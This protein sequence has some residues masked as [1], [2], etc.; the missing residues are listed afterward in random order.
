MSRVAMLSFSVMIPRR[1]SAL[2]KVPLSDNEMV[3]EAEGGGAAA[4]K[5]EEHHQSNLRVVDT[6]SMSMSTFTEEEKEKERTKHLEEEDSE[7]VIESP[8]EDSPR[9]FPPME[10]S[11]CSDV[12]SLHHEDHIDLQIRILENASLSVIARKDFE[13]FPVHTLQCP[14]S[15]RRTEFVSF[16]K[17]KFAH[18]ASD[19]GFAVVRAKKIQNV[20]SYKLLS[21]RPRCNFRTRWKNAI[22]L[23][24]KQNKKDQLIEDSS[25]RTGSEEESSNNGEEEA[26]PEDQNQ[27]VNIRIR[28]LEDP[29]IQ[30]MSKEVLDRFPVQALRCPR[31]LKEEEFLSL[32]RSTFPQLAPDRPFQVLRNRPFKRL[33]RINLN[34]LTPQEICRLLQNPTFCLRLMSPLS[35]QDEEKQEDLQN[36]ELH[37]KTPPT[38]EDVVHMNV[39]LLEDLEAPQESRVIHHLDCPGDLQES[40]FLDLLRSS[41]PQ[42]RDQTVE[43]LTRTGDRLLPVKTQHQTV[44]EIR[45]NVAS[46]DD[47]VLYV[48]VQEGSGEERPAEPLLSDSP[49]ADPSEDEPVELK[50][51]ILEDQEALGF[52]DETLLSHPTYVLQCPRLLQEEEFLKVLRSTFPQLAPD[53]PFKVFKI[54]DD[55]TLQPLPIQTLTPQEVCRLG[56]AATICIR[57][58]DPMN[59]Q[60]KKIKSEEDEDPGGAAHRNPSDVWTGRQSSSRH[61]ANGVSA[62]VCLLRS[63]KFTDFLVKH[64]KDR[65]ESGPDLS[66]CFQLSCKVCGRTHP[67]VCGLVKHAWGHVH[68]GVGSCGV[69]GG[70]AASTEE[71]KNHLL[72]HQRSHTCTVCGKFFI[73]PSGFKTLARQH[74]DPRMH[75]CGTCQRDFRTKLMLTN[76][77]KLHLKKESL[78]GGYNSQ[79][80]DGKDQTQRR[81]SR[82]TT[83]R[84]R[85]KSQKNNPFRC[86]KC[87][88]TFQ[89]KVRLEKHITVR[90]CV[91]P[92][93]CD[94]CGARFHSSVSMRKHRLTHMVVK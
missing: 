76:H 52:S 59:I 68:E 45:Q 32:L 8:S 3:C 6:W 34:P 11:D 4:K 73:A 43:L 84:R 26:Q 69:C 82:R 51:C 16:I 41:F 38:V 47:S 50:I 67:S 55:R 39:C 72:I 5:E 78:Q 61:E 56:G 64:E 37:N 27:E 77:M 81:K 14:R 74:S 83:G 21:L 20:P 30:F 33:R 12:G 92:Y 62:Y 18:L 46:S 35:A 31:S 65:T 63:P 44:K 87:D 1:M 23:R 80:G 66:G 40:P 57:L 49:A 79:I 19:T 94:V 7:D 42:L 28:I 48:R 85:R 9:L 75:C 36:S 54:G 91:K 10:L 90:V 13:H 25:M 24:P 29:T 89:S 71:L 17:S 86:S 15:L 88:R 93:T 70:K 53:K 60:D 58:Q 2:E 22:C